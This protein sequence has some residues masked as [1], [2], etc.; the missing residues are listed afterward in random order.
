M[1]YRNQI[2]VNEMRYTFNKLNIFSVFNCRS[3][4]EKTEKRIFTKRG[5]YSSQNTLGMPT[6]LHH[7]KQ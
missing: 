7:H 6:R 3:V 4:K 5:L 2:N 1:I